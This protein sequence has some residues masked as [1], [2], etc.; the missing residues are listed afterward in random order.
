MV[1]SLEMAAD[2]T[3]YKCIKWLCTQIDLGLRVVLLIIY[4]L[5]T[6]ESSKLL[7]IANKSKRVAHS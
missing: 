2:C 3:L 1:S 6:V 7:E 4:D 5:A